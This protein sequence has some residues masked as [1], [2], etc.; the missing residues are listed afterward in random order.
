MPG[1]RISDILSPL[2]SGDTYPVIDVDVNAKG[3]ARAVSSI[4]HRDAIPLS[5]RSTSLFVLVVDQSQIFRWTGSTWVSV[6]FLVA[7]LSNKVQVWNE[8]PSGAVNG[9]NAKFVLQYLPNPTNSLMLFKNGL[10]MREGVGNDYTLS[11]LEI[12]FIDE[13]TPQTGDS[14]ICSYTRSE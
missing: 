4:A 11:G 14:I 8:V 7:S 10:I 5:L 6:G 1:V 12:N 9:S 3:F 2:S 13:Q